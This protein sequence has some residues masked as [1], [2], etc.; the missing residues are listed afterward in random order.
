MFTF[1]PSVCPYETYRYG[2]K[3]AKPVES[4]LFL[5]LIIL[6]FSKINA[7]TKFRQYRPL[8]L[9]SGYVCEIKLYNQLSSPR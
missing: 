3:T 2:D 4:N 6:V 7:G 1:R 8:V 5:V 9:V